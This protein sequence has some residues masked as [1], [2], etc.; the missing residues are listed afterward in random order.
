M[1][2]GEEIFTI[3]VIESFISANAGMVIRI[4]G[5]GVAAVEA[6]LEMLGRHVTFPFILRGEP[7]LAAVVG[8]RAN[9]RTAVTT[10]VTRSSGD[11]FR[12]VLGRGDLSL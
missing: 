7:A 5:A 10:L 1:M 6:Q 9:E 12:L 2:L 3:E 4:A 8:E 11:S